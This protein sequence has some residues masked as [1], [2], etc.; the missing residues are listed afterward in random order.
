MA[1]SAVS[2]AVEN[3]YKRLASE[4]DARVCTDISDE[5]CHYVLVN[6]MGA[7]GY[8]MALLVPAR[9]SGSLIP[10]QGMEPAFNEPSVIAISWLGMPEWKPAAHLA[11]GAD[12]G[13]VGTDVTHDLKSEHIAGAHRIV[14][15]LP[16][17]YDEGD[18]R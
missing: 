4:E 12:P 10:Q 5:A 14:V 15:H 8:V 13:R 1:A 7:P 9:E 17:G 16:A 3:A 2:Q 6:F 18:R 11:P